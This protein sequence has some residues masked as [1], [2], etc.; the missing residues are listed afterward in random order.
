MEIKKGSNR[1]YIGDSEENDLA[2]ITWTV[3]GKD[4]ILINHT[5]VSPELRG[6]NIAGRL[7]AKVVE[8]ARNENLKVKPVCSYAVVKLTRTDEYE[9]ILFRG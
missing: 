3:G 2:R 1:F 7:L 8:M 9:D 4:L 5:F 6:Q